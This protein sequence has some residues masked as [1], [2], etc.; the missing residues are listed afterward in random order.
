MLTGQE[1]D[2]KNIDFCPTEVRSQKVGAMGW[3]VILSNC[4]NGKQ[5][6]Q[7]IFTWAIT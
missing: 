7:E 6:S 2:E 1:F 4:H 3:F 5:Y